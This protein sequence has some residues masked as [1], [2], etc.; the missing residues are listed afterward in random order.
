MKIPLW[1]NYS[2]VEHFSSLMIENFPH[3]TKF[4]SLYHHRH[5]ISMWIECE[6]EVKIQSNSISFGKAFSTKTPGVFSL[7]NVVHIIIMCIAPFLYIFSLTCSCTY[8]PDFMFYD[9][10]LTC[11]TTTMMMMYSHCIHRGMAH[12]IYTLFLGRVKG[13]FFWFCSKIVSLSNYIGSNLVLLSSTSCV[14]YSFLDGI[15]ACL[16]FIPLHSFI[17]D[18]SSQCF[19]M[20]KNSH[21]KIIEWKCFY[22]KIDVRNKEKK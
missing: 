6:K 4:S 20:H 14:C 22:E 16:H 19:N 15:L 13:F 2:H 3:Y 12:S 18:R 1:K 21:G 5:W 9:C 10:A 7:I 8:S 11:Y 17:A